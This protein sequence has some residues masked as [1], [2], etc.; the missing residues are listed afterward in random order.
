[1]QENQEIDK[2]KLRKLN[3]LREKGIEAYPYSFDNK[4][5]AKKINEKYSSIKEGEEVKESIAVAG[6]IM[7]LRRMGKVT[8]MHIQDETGRVQLYFQQD[9]LGKE[10]YKLLKKLDA[11]DII[12]TEGFIFKTKTGEVTVHVEK[13]QILTKSLRLLPEKYHGIKDKEARYRQRYLDLIMNHDVKE[14]FFKRSLMIK[15]IRDYF[16]KQ[17][18]V[19]VETPALQTIY[20]GANARPFKTHINAWDM[21]MFL[22]ISPELYLKRIIVGGFEKIFTISKNFRNEGVDHSH[23]PEFTMLEAYQAYADYKDMMK[24]LEECYEKCALAL[25]G[26]TKVKHLHKTKREGKLVEEEVEIDF[27]APWP[28]KTMAEL[29][30]E[31]AG[32][33]VLSS[34]K[35]DLHKF[36][37]DNNLD[38][39]GN[40]KEK[41]WGDSVLIIFEE[42]CEDKLVQPV[43]VID[44]PFESTPLCKKH[45]EDERLIERF[46]SFALGM[47][48][49]NAYSELNDPV[50]QRKLLEE[51]A[52]KGRAGDEEAHPM[53]EDFIES[54]EYGMPPTG[55]L[56]FGIDR[57]AILLT[58]A[59]TIRDVIMFP[60]M[61]PLEQN[62]DSK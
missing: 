15:T 22:S 38:L 52:E 58:G 11:G 56:G 54:I 50:K 49:S 62:T 43:H 23:N 57:M 39:E 30:E 4:N 12:G 28:R 48:L 55:G 34:K 46:E 41:S 40:L 53:D 32:I 29:I 2:E 59:E 25:N 47:E 1:M 31:H 26:S 45:R 18:F 44:H 7:Q 8:F 42:L 17:K 60:T 13:Y 51:Q 9:S 27:K 20:G 10:A 16:D 19:E 37:A 14:V 21:D 3:E 6:R 24:L 5:C 35:E 33:D 61:K 36:I